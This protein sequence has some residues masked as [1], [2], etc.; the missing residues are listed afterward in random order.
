MQVHTITALIT[1]FDERGEIDFQALDQLIQFQIDRKTEGLVLCG[2]T[3]EGCL[4]TREEK[5][6]VF[7][8]AV[9][10]GKGE[11][12]LI[13][14]I[15]GCCTRKSVDL[16]KDAENLGVDACIA[17]VPYYVKPTEQGCFIHFS[18]IAK[19]GLPLFVY[20]HPGRTGTKLSFEALARIAEIPGVVGLKEASGDLKLAEQLIQKGVPFFSGEDVLCQHHLQLGAQGSISIT[21]NV[22]PD[23]WWEFVK[24]KE[25]D[26]RL[27]KLS[28]ALVLE[29]NPQCIKYAVSLSGRCKLQ[30]RL[31][32]MAP[33]E[34]SQL[35]IREALL[36][37]ES[38]WR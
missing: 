11:I 2:S 17:T 18:E 1:P 16:A 32:L 33:T 27:Q 13:A 28:E 23:L 7:H 5:L 15:G 3:G 6:S 19:V 34:E 30:Y 8:R 25:M 12:Q 36:T 35:K 22:A 31:P 10:L 24:S 21:G 26:S 20:H 14:N 38:A 37:V 4:L 29:T 9:E